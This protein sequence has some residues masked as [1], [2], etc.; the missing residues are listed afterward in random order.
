MLKKIDIR[1]AI[2]NELKRIRNDVK[3]NI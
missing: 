1:N 3:N 2:K